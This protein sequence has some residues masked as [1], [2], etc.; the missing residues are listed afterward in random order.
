VIRPAGSNFHGRFGMGVGGES[1]DG[2]AT[3]SAR[4]T[5]EPRSGR[6]QLREGASGE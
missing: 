3:D 2:V 1:V 5:L 4:S 6:D